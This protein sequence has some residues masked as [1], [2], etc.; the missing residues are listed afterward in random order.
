LPKWSNKPRSPTAGERGKGAE[1]WE[2][3]PSGKKENN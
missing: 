1:N 3:I 2:R